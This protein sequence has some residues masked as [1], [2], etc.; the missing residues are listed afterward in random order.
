V[1]DEIKAGEI[2]KLKSGGP[3]M[4]V[5]TVFND[6]HAKRCVKCVWFDE[7]R[8]VRDVFQIEAVEIT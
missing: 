8:L 2:V 5:E 1:S 4:T 6:A 3:K 7:N